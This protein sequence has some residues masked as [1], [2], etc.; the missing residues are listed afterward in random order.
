MSLKFRFKAL[1]AIRSS[2]IRQV[3]P[4]EQARGH[5]TSSGD[6]AATDHLIAC[7]LQNATITDTRRG[8][9]LAG[10]TPGDRDR[11][12]SVSRSEAEPDQR[13]K[14]GKC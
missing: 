10:Q 1:G 4:L 11:H 7:V 8:N 13:R 3:I 6:T 2:H 5:A 9:A 12:G 14:A